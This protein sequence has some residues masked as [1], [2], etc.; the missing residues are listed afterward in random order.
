MGRIDVVVMEYDC[1]VF[2]ARFADRLTERLALEQVEI[3]SGWKYED[4]ARAP[5]IDRGGELVNRSQLDIRSETEYRLAGRSYCTCVPAIRIGNED[6]RRGQCSLPPMRPCFTM[7]ASTSTM[8]R[9]AT[10]AVMSEMS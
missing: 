1:G 4:L 5:A 9:T 8:A 2:A 6:E 10:S 7:V 3:K